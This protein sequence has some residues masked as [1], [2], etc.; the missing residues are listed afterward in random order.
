MSAFTDKDDPVKFER[1]MAKLNKMD[2]DLAQRMQD[3]ARETDATK[4]HDKFI[5]ALTDV[6]EGEYDKYALSKAGYEFNRLAKMDPKDA[7]YKQTFEK[8]S[9]K[10]NEIIGPYLEGL[11]KLEV[12]LSKDGELTA[13]DHRILNEAQKGFSDKIRQDQ[14]MQQA[15]VQQTREVEFTR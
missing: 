3:V 14:P 6:H 11:K 9:P 1:D 12:A 8:L 4:S 10:E 7:D 5:A 15:D 2:P 13:L